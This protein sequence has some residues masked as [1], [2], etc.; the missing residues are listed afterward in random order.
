MRRHPKWRKRLEQLIDAIERNPFA[1]G[2]DDCG[3]NWAGAA[4][5]AVLG[6]DPAAPYRGRYA[7]AIGAL[8]IMRSAGHDNLADM[9]RALLAEATGADCEIHPSEARAGDLMAVPDDSGFGYLLAI[10]NGERILVRRPDGKGTME[11]LVAT[12]AWRIGDA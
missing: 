7:S 5:E 12:R 6:I 4:V 1:Y 9:V 11:R 2:P 8:R 10:C 3:P